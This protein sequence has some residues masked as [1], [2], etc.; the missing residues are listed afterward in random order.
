MPGQSCPGRGVWLPMVLGCHV[1]S[2][3]GV[4]TDLQGTAA[5][6][7]CRQASVVQPSGGCMQEANL[8]GLRHSVLTVPVVADI[9]WRAR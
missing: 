5:A 9:V 8:L 6:S 3:Q 2:P 7:E 1:M 4:V